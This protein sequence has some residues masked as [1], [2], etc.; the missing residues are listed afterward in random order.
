MIR[1]DGPDAIDW[2]EDRLAAGNSENCLPRAPGGTVAGGAGRVNK[3][4]TATLQL[5]TI[6]SYAPQDFIHPIWTAGGHEGPLRSPWGG[7][8]VP[9]HTPMSRSP[10]YIVLKM[11]YALG[12]AEGALSPM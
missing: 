8:M 4:F 11:R 5:I 3:V 12:N 9:V 6:N 1:T 7:Y 2:L 10:A